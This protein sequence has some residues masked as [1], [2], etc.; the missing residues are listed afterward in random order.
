[1]KPFKKIYYALLSAIFVCLCL[2]FAACRNE[3][4]YFSY[5]SELR[6]NIFLAETDD[7]SLRVFSVKRESPYA[8]DGIPKEIFSRTEIYLRAPSHATHYT[9]T[10]Q[11]GEQTLGGE[12]SYDNVKSEYYLYSPVDISTFDA[13]SCVIAYGDTE[14][15]LQALSVMEKDCLSCENALKQLVQTE[16]ELFASL[17]D[18]YGFCGEIYLRLIYEDAPYYYIGVIDRNQ[19]VYAFLMHAKSGKILAKR[20]S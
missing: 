4:D 10:L 17:T 7:F 2:C 20:Q 15:S 12:L 18:K 5:V 8:A 16:S 6:N 19:N 3:I 11:A 14:I 1:M 9:I 13:V